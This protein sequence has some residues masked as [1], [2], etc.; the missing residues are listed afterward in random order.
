[1]YGMVNKAIKAC[2]IDHYN[3]N[4]WQEVKKKA[5]TTTDEFIS[6]EQYPDED[7]VALVVAGAEVL[8]KEPGEM[9][10]EIGEYWIEFAL[11]SD[12]GDLLRMAGNTLSEL[13]INLDNMHVRVGS[14][15]PNLQPPSFWCTNVEKGS[16][17]LH[18][19]SKRPGLAQFV[20]G[21]VK[22]LA[23]MLSISCTI[24]QTA[25]RDQGEDHDEF[26]V[27]YS[28]APIN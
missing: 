17:I 12:Y 7:S 25:F 10:E 16:L 28:E 27:K 20:V 1:M 19:S 4:T 23:S 26:A 9:L 21:L 3:I 24:Q 11:N 14:S 8:N 5:R 13:L 15:F 18:Y 6:M 2:I 22:G